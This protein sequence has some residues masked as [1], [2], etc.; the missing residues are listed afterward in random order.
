MGSRPRPGIGAGELG[1][2]RAA[3]QRAVDLAVAGGNHWATF[4]CTARLTILE[5]EAGDL[6]AA[7][8]RCAALGELAAR[9]GSRGSETAYAAAIAT[10]AAVAGRKRGAAAALDDAVVELERMDAG[11]LAPDLLGIA[12]E[13]EF[14]AGDGS[15]ALAH[16]TRAFEEL[17]RSA[18]RPLETARARVVLACLRAKRREFDEA[19][20]H[21]KAVAGDDGRLSIMWWRCAGRRKPW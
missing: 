10:L 9:L 18:G 17:A 19:E 13:A 14:R 20:A 12:A 2:A 21:L 8:P 7:G 1:E 5:L 4:E 6:N 11:F 16:A 15:T 3:L